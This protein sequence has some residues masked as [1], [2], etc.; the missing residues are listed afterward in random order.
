[1]AR[2]KKKKTGKVRVFREPKEIGFALVKTGARVGGMVSA[3]VV[4]NKVVAMVDAIPENLRPLIPMGIGI[5]GEIFLQ[6]EYANRFFSGMTDFGIVMMTAL[7]VPQATKQK[8]A[9]IPSPSKGSGKNLGRVEMSSNRTDQ[10]LL[11]ELVEYQD[12]YGGGM[13]GHETVPT[14]NLAVV[15]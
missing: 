15:S 1:M 6:N 2:R 11:D 13:A 9:L 7:N 8:L 5:M 14:A 10:E 12:E 4:T 3:A